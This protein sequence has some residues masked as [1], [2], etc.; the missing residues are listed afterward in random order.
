MAGYSFGA[1]PTAGLTAEAWRGAG[2]LYDSLWRGVGSNVVA[3]RPRNIVD[4]LE[5]D[6]FEIAVLAASRT[7]DVRETVAL[8]NLLTVGHRRT[9]RDRRSDRG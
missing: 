4:I 3:H 6:H 7:I 2:L 1:M 8:T 9:D 5:T